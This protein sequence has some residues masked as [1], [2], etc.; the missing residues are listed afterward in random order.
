MN[1]S[2]LESVSTFI[3]IPA[4]IFSFSSKIKSEHL[5]IKLVEQG[6]FDMMDW[7]RKSRQHCSD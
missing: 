1:I 3:C 7:Y 4:P 5:Q 6:S 2:L